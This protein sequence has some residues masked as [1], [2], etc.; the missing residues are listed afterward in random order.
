VRCGGQFRPEE[1]YKQ[2][3][4]AQGGS[5]KHA[6]SVEAHRGLN[7]KAMSLLH[8]VLCIEGHLWAYTT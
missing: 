3:E 8:K 4:I 1:N 5:K 2:L 6:Y 7:N